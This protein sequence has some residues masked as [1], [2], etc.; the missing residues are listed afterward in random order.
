MLFRVITL[1]IVFAAIILS[2]FIV[3][4]GLQAL[5]WL[6]VFLL[7]VS[8]GNIYMTLNYYIKLRNAPGVRGERGDPGPKGQKGSN[9]VCTIDTSCGSIQNCHDFT[10]E[11]F[12]E[13]LPEY[14]RVVDKRNR[15]IK[16]N[17]EDLKILSQVNEYF[18]MIKSACESGRY[19]QQ[20]LRAKV[21]KSLE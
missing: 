18:E 14:R 12:M 6:I 2:R 3:D 10:E 5:Y 19:S 17:T 21:K 7:T 11:I 13:Q 16:L 8:V 15:D 4:R 1:S 9:G 20:E